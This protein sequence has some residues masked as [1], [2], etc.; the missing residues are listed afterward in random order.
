MPVTVICD[1]CGNTYKR[2]PSRIKNYERHFCSEVC[3]IAWWKSLKVIT[4]CPECGA[5]FSARP[6]WG[7]KFC[8]RKCSGASLSRRYK[9]QKP[10]PQCVKAS[11]EAASKRLINPEV[12]AK[13][14]AA[15]KK[16]YQDA[17][18]LKDY[19]KRISAGL[20]TYYET[21]DGPNKGRKCPWV[22]K[23]NAQL[24]GEKNYNW[25]GGT[26]FEPYSPE[27]TK[28]I[29]AKIRERDNFRC[30]IC[31]KTEIENGRRLSVHHIDFN[32]LNC[33]LDNLMTVCNS[34]H[35][36]ITN[37]YSGCIEQP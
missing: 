7:K 24:T 13:M 9:G 3:R 4:I 20:K 32:K 37:E 14:Q 15:L 31:G 30:S 1:W 6:S 16:K 23:R 27:W 34:C 26:S 19:G 33:A 35:A 29:R 10:S 22:G 18:W 36:Q 5:E 17:Q 28:E 8:S 21:R 2:K 12:Q 25:K 11:A